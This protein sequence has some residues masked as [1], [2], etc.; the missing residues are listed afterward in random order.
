VSTQNR[1]DGTPGGTPDGTPD[2]TP[3]GGPGA[4]PGPL[5]RTGRAA[6]GLRSTL[7]GARVAELEAEVGDLRAR[8]AELE[9]AAVEARRHQLRVAE[10]TD[11]VQALLVPLAT[12]DREG[13]DE[14]LG[15]YAE[16]LG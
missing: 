5:A 13:L 14:V 9:E 3:S 4:G 12:A 1:P 10:L 2:G 16:Q 15:R 6:R 7:S 11:V 8:V